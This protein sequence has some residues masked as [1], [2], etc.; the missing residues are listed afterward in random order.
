MTALTRPD[1]G[2]LHQVVAGL[3]A[4]VE[5]AGDVVGQRQAPL[6][7]PVALTLEL[8]RLLGQ[9]LKL[10]EHV[11]DVRVFRVRS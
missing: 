7:D 5:P 9:L 8:R 11:G 4:P 1:A 3:T 6:D 2:H 10:A